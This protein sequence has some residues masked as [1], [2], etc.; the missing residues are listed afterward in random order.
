[1]LRLTGPSVYL[2]ICHYCLLLPLY[3]SIL[4]VAGEKYVLPWLDYH[5]SSCNM[6]CDCLPSFSWWIIFAWVF[7]YCDPNGTLL[8]LIILSFATS[9]LVFLSMFVVSFIHLGLIN[10]SPFFTQNI[11]DCE[12]LLMGILVV[13]RCMHGLW[14]LCGS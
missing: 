6:D 13:L 7:P 14:L 9:L 1:M 3:F 10:F 12:N 5:H 8:R 11:I 4:C 2:S